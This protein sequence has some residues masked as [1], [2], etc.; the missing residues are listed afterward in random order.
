MEY[1]MF[2][3]IHDDL[4]TNFDTTDEFFDLLLAL[5]LWADEQKVHHHKHEAHE[6]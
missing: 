6:P 1:S 3:T 5:A 4:I 2:S